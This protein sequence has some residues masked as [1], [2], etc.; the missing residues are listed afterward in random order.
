MDAQ[1][2]SKRVPPALLVARYKPLAHEGYAIL[3]NRSMA[4]GRV[5]IAPTVHD[6]AD[7]GRR[8]AKGLGD[9]CGTVLAAPG[10]VARPDDLDLSG[11][12][13][14]GASHETP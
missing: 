4:A 5:P 8:H 14:T 6:I 9:R 10:Y 12:K 2:S 13:L 3:R 11:G 1:H 7:G